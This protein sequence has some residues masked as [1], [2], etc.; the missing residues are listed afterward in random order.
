MH[1]A[2]HILRFSNPTKNWDQEKKVK[3]EYQLIK[4]SVHDYV[5]YNSDLQSLVFN[6]II[7]IE[8]SGNMVHFNA[9]YWTIFLFWT[10]QWF[11]IQT[12]NLM[13]FWFLG[14][15][16]LFWLKKKNNFLIAFSQPVN[17]FPHL[18]LNDLMCWR[19]SL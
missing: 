13:V 9:F 8:V 1:F 12:I 11:K 18:C 15:G 6:F 4:K 17:L 2:D 10:F 7:F 3:N 14:V 5:S 16:F 19:G